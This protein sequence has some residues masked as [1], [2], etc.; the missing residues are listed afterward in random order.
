MKTI[1]QFQFT[2]HA[3]SRF[4]QR[5]PNSSIEV[6][7]RTAEYIKPERQSQRSSMGRRLLHLS[8]P[9]KFLTRG[10]AVFVCVEAEGYYKV[11]TVI[12]YLKPNE[13]IVDDMV[14]RIIEKN[15]K[16]PFQE[17]LF[18]MRLLTNS[19]LDV[20]R[21]CSVYR[22]LVVQSSA[23]D[24]YMSDADLFA[25]RKEMDLIKVSEQIEVEE[26]F[27]LYNQ[28]NRKLSPTFNRKPWLMF[29]V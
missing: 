4:N 27:S 22:Y 11:I 5:F 24:G 16:S 14:M 1:G 3:L 20:L 2:K 6:E 25:L 26:S 18:D 13:N 19:R 29:D 23:L 7:A 8:K 15:N 28:I 21:S 10:E 9:M 17:G 12:L